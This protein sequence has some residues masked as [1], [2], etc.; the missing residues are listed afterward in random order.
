M[1][2]IIGPKIDGA[3]NLE[4]AFSEDD[5][6]F[7][8]MFSSVSMVCGNA[9]QSLYAAGCGYLNGLA[10]KRRRCGLAGST[11][12]IGRVVGLGYVE[13]ADQ[14]VRDQL[15]G[16]GLKPISESDL[17]NAFAETIWAG[18][19]QP[20]DK[21]TLPEAVVT[22]GVRHFREDED[23][24]GP[25]FTDPIFSHCIIEKPKNQSSSGDQRKGNSLPLSQQ[26]VQVASRK[27]A[28]DVITGKMLYESPLLEIT[29]IMLTIIQILSR[30]N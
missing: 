13:S 9:G 8:V 24:K 28:L 21:D 2:Q 29:L 15:I 1:Q 19:P 12:D 27:E 25:W 3:I 5:L 18:F 22:M 11:F 30:I 4:N 26:L 23:V 16:L 14:I 17:R 20:Q 10:R 6:D 7:F